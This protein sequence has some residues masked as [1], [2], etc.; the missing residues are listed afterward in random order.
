MSAS[1]VLIV[2]DEK[3]IRL[4]LSLA[5]ESLNLPLDAAASA[6]EALE[7]L[8]AKPR[9]FGL[10]LLDLQM[11][12]L[13]GMEMLRRLAQSRP[14]IKVIIIT[15]H[16][17]VDTAVAAM[18]LG[19]VDFLQ[20]PF[21]P[22]EIRTLVS[23]VLAREEFTGKKAGDYQTYLELALARVKEEQLAAARVYAHKAIFLD[24]ARPEAF[25][26]LGGIAE[27]QGQRQ[28][29]DKNYRAALTLDP[30]FPPAQ[31]NLT[32]I[33]SRPYRPSGIVWSK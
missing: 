20:K 17:S 32:R 28:D 1:G 19:A 6:E 4:T 22:M 9:A 24:P 15:A 7:M 2:D 25:N 11:P 27:V 12:G 30:T 8:A 18:K 33:T 16:G 29:A 31:Q 23:R 14:D 5:L 26:I 3:N 13:G 21:N 10:I